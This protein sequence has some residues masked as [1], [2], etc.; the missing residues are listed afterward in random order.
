MSYE[1]DVVTDAEQYTFDKV[2]SACTTE[3]GA[4][5]WCMQTGLLAKSALCPKCGADMCLSGVRWRCNRSDCRLERSV[6]INSFFSRSSAPLSKLVKI[7]F[8]WASRTHVT[9]ACEHTRLSARSAGQWYSFA[10]D[11]CSA[12][13]LRCDMQVCTVLYLADY[14]YF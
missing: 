1:Y 4:V 8:F 2:M 13:M 6:R 9:E 12:E 11:I 5:A 14:I 10:R 7:L 3:Q